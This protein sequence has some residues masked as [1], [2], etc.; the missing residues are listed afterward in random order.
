MLV[1]VRSCG[2]CRRWMLLIDLLFELIV[3]NVH[4]VETYVAFYVWL[5]QLTETVW[6]MTV[7][8]LCWL[9]A[10]GGI[11]LS[12]CPWESGSTCM[13]LWSYTSGF[14][15]VVFHIICHVVVVLYQFLCIAHIWWV[16]VKDLLTY[17]LTTFS[18]RA[19]FWHGIAVDGLS[20]KSSSFWNCTWWSWLAH[21]MSL[22]TH[23]CQL[24]LFT[25]NVITLLSVTVAAVVLGGAAWEVPWEEASC[26]ASFERCCRCCILH[27]LCHCL[28]FCCCCCFVQQQLVVLILLNVIA[29]SC[30]LDC[31]VCYWLLLMSVCAYIILACDIS[32]FL[33]LYR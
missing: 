14:C 1:L 9:L 4:L 11:L 17:L 24:V 18:E 7:V 26:C 21:A 28:C 3:V 19:L 27:G 6:E 13:H 25:V 5:E 16:T 31:C 23:C 29:Q 20:L 2:R 15:D 22:I 30:L 12:G 33:W 10:T 32:L 8:S